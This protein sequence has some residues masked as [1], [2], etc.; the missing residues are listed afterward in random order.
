MR[1]LFLLLAVRRGRRA[2]A[3]RSSS[4]ARA[5]TPTSRTSFRRAAGGPTGEANTARRPTLG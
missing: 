4:T 1:I 5:K 2:G 3:V